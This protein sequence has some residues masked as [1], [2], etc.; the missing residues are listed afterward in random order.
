MAGKPKK[1]H[2]ARSILKNAGIQGMFVSELARAAQITP[3]SINRYIENEW[4]DK[5]RVEKRGGL[6]FVY[7]LK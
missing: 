3:T 5:V 4:K 2:I 1:E 7:W 6:T